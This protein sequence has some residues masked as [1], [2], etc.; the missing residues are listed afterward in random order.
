M[1]TT[2]GTEPTQVR[3]PWRAVLR[4]ALQVG[5]PLFLLLPLMIQII[6]DELGETLPPAFTAWLLAAAGV[7]TAIA[8]VIARLMAIPQVEL[9]L[10]QLP[11]AAFAAQPRPKPDNEAR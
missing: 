10:R 7:I 9:L 4:T 1:S 6:V 8:A 11:G 2:Q 3:R 5:I